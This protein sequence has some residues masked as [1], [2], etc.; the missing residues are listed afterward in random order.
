M[1]FLLFPFSKG[2]LLPDFLI[3]GILYSLKY[4][5]DDRTHNFTLADNVFQRAM[6]TPKQGTLK[7]FVR[8]LKVQALVDTGLKDLK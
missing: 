6:L 2:Q 8:Q 7:L 4:L 1:I 5:H 3:W